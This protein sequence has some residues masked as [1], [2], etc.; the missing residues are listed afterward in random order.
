MS[1]QPD[2]SARAKVDPLEQAQEHDPLADISRPGGGTTTTALRALPGRKAKLLEAIAS[3]LSLRQACELSQ[4]TRSSVSRWRQSDPVFRE[5]Y[6]L[7]AEDG[8]DRIR[9]A[10][11]LRAVEGWKEEVFG[12]E[13]FLG[14]R[15]LFSDKLL[16]AMAQARCPEY[17]PHLDSTGIDAAELA[18]R[19][20]EADAHMNQS[21]PNPPSTQAAPS[22]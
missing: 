10:I 3:G 17:K 22:P 13:G 21:V 19:L 20:R 1:S 4:I 2:D 5:R 15:T 6:D 8:A 12:K 16:L 7:A 18:R 9:E 14:H 11:H